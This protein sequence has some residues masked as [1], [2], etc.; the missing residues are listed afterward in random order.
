LQ[1]AVETFV[2]LAVESV[3]NPDESCVSAHIVL[4][5]YFKL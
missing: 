4:S 5:Q 3:W 2:N 1:Y